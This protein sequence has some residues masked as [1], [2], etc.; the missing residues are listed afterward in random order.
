MNARTPHYLVIWEFQVNPEAKL[1]FEQAYG[2]AG[3]W[4]RLFSRSPDF[5][6]TELLR[7]IDRPGRYLTFDHWTSRQALRQFKQAHQAD[8]DAL[9]RQC[10]AL[11]RN[12]S[13]LGEFEFPSSTDPSSSP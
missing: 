9:D 8:Y 4:A 12:E 10:E 7:D 3:D 1:A 13:L 6:G 2:P 11:T 5:R